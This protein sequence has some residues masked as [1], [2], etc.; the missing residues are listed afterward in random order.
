MKR[1]ALTTALFM[2]LSLT[3][4][5]ADEFG[6]LNPEE[7]GPLRLAENL[8]THPDRAGILC[9]V[10]YEMQK[11]GGDHAERAFEAMGTCAES[12]NAPSMI[13][14]SHAYENGFGTEVNLELSTHWVREAALS[15]YSMGAYHYGMALLKGQGT[16]TDRG[17]AVKWLQQAADDGI[18]DAIAVLET[19]SQ[20]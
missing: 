14:L 20:G 6:T 4:A 11:G 12:G 1:L 13:M 5:V 19:L 10:V 17:E 8:A 3:P 18:E 9:W 16:E 15:G 7:G 2:S